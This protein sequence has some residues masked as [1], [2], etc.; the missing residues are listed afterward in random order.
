M[1]LYFISF[2]L[3]LFFILEIMHARIFSSLFIYLFIYSFLDRERIY[4]R[5]HTFI[6]YFLFSIIN[7]LIEDF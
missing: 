4:F 2:I 3:S 5:Y 6:V 7:F 1:S